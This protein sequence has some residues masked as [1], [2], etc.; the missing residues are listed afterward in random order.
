MIAVDLA[1]SRILALQRVGNVTE[2][3]AGQID[4]IEFLATLP[5]V[6]VVSLDMHPVQLQAAR[7]RWP[8]ATMVI[9]KRHLLGMIDRDVLALAARVVLGWLG[10]DGDPM[11]VRKAVASFGAAA[12]PYLSLRTLVLRRQHVLTAADQATWAMLRREGG[13][14]EVLWQAY[15]WREALYDVYD[16]SLSAAQMTDGL[17]RWKAGMLKWYHKQ[18][19]E[20]AT[21][22]N[23]PLGGIKWAIAKHWAACLAY[24]ETGLTNAGTESMNAQVRRV[25][26]RGHRY[27]V[28]TVVQLVNSRLAAPDLATRHVVTLPRQRWVR[29]PSAA[30]LSVSPAIQP[31]ETKRPVKRPPRHE[32]HPTPSAVPKLPPAAPLITPVK[33]NKRSLPRSGGLVNDAAWEWLHSSAEPHRRGG[34]RWVSR[35]VAQAPEEMTASWRLLCAGQLVDRHREPV[36]IDHLGLWRGYVL[37]RFAVTRTERLS[38]RV[39]EETGMLESLDICALHRVAPEALKALSEVWERLTAAQF[40]ASTAEEMRHLALLSRWHTLRDKAEA[41]LS[42]RVGAQRDRVLWD[43]W[44]QAALKLGTQPATAVVR[45]VRPRLDTLGIE[46]L[47]QWMSDE[48]FRWASAVEWALAEGSLSLRALHPDDGQRAGWCRHLQ[49]LINNEQVVSNVSSVVIGTSL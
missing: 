20:D 10:Q 30:M 22:Y 33:G 36:P 18:P 45:V 41:L 39:R 11:G 23:K 15:Q 7:A 34:Q 17:Q 2:G 25:L 16:A 9:D 35:V 49:T 43:I 13:L 48:T 1:G 14:S 3:R 38:G 5:E 29:E 26:R 46:T 40:V 6:S 47:R 12:Y 31:L 24:A 8:E 27:D 32:D 44:C 21:R 28:D 19:W 42:T 4:I 37:H